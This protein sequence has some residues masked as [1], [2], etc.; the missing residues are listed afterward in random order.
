MPERSKDNKFKNRKTEKKNGTTRTPSSEESRTVAKSLF[1]SFEVVSLP[2]LF[3]PLL[4]AVGDAS[5]LHLQLRLAAPVQEGHRDRRVMLCRA[6][7]QSPC[8]RCLKFCRVVDY[9]LH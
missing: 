6:E 4:L 8:H 1:N 5:T 3:R 7:K 9:E 2:A